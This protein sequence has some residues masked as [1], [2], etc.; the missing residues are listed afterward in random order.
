MW[1]SKSLP[2]EDQSVS[3]VAKWTGVVHSHSHSGGKPVP[4]CPKP[5]QQIRREAVCEL[6]SRQVRDVCWSR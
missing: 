2:T 1:D 4:A 6:D 3:E 5:G